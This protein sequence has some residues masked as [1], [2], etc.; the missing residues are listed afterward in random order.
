M[1]QPPAAQRRNPDQS[2]LCYQDAEHFDGAVRATRYEPRATLLRL[3]FFFDRQEVLH[4]L[5][6]RERLALDP[7]TVV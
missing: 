3:R 6:H 2:P 5:A 1:R 4:D 7:E